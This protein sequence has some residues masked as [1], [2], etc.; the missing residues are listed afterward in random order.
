MVSSATI[1]VIRNGIVAHITSVIGRW[2]LTLV[3]N[4]LR[5]TGGWRYP[6]SR[7]SRKITPRWYGSM[8]YALAI[9]PISG[10]TTTMAEKMSI[11]V[12]T[13]SRITLIASRN[14]IFDS[15]WDWVHA[16]SLRGTSSVTMKLV[17][18]VDA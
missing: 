3:M 10:S 1:I 6:T 17:S 14:T 7:L 9:G 8:P 13:I 11:T 2:N 16:T 18:A 15:T 5:P 4:R 12:P